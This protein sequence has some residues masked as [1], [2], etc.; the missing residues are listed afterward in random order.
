MWL[1]G[2]LAALRLPSQ[3]EV[4][5]AWASARLCDV[6]RDRFA[7]PVAR[8]PC[9]GLRLGIGAERCGEC[10]RAPPPY[11]RAVVAFDYGFPWDRLIA[12]FKYEG[13]A[14]LAAPLAR[15]LVDAVHRA[16]ATQPATAAA[17]DLVVPMP[18]SSARLA[19]RGFNQAWELARRV[20]RDLGLPA[21][22]DALQRAIDTPHQAALTRSERERNLRAAFM[23]ASRM[24]AR[25]AGQRIA[26]VDDVMTTG[27]TAREA[28]LALRRAGASSVH[29]WVLARTPS[30]GAR[31]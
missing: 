4:C 19:E 20:A 27:A 5:R 22:A 7:A 6:C 12:A 28:A 13:Q 3:C 31:C 23:A 16:G 1:A 8:C 24:R 21:R 26:L 30:P 9:C 25:L 2:S 29:L 18:L 14:E 11:D 17:V 15:C 10:M